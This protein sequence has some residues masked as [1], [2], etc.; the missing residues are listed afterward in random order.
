MDEPTQDTEEVTSDKSPSGSLVIGGV[1]MLILAVLLSWVPILGPLAAGFVGGRLIGEE[2]KAL[3]VAFLPAV[4]MG[5]V[6]WLVLAAFEL[7]L[8]GAVAGFGA[9]VV[10]AVQELPLLAGAWF[11]GSSPMQRS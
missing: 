11:G 10:I 9:L 7:P 3:A 6:V 8:L 4:L 2:K 1:W 5:I